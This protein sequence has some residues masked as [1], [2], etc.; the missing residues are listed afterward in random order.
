VGA[1]A[2]DIGQAELE[3]LVDAHAGERYAADRG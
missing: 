3:I 2:V 1:A